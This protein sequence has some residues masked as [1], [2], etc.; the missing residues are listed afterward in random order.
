MSMGT[1]Q[2][3]VIVEEVLWQDYNPEDE[4]IVFVDDD[5]ERDSDYDAQ[6]CIYHSYKKKNRNIIFI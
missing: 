1:P 5:S 2:N 6:D 4:D 3:E